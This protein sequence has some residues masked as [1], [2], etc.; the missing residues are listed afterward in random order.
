MAGVPRT[1]GHKRGR[2]CYGYS[3]VVVVLK[4]YGGTDCGRQ[5]WL[6]SGDRPQRADAV[7]EL[8]SGVPSG[9]SCNVP[10]D[11]GSADGNDGGFERNWNPQLG[12]SVARGEAR[13]VGERNGLAERWGQNDG[14]A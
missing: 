1:R 12:R 8:S 3:A 4:V 7:G 2:I 6:G 10:R 9:A 5:V 13:V 14:M 11:M